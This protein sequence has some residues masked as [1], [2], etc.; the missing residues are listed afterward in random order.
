M[1]M[2]THWKRASALL[3]ATLLSAAPL[4]AEVE[5]EFR[6]R[7]KERL[8]QLLPSVDRIDIATS[9]V[10]GIYEVIVNG[11]VL[12][13]SE[14]ARH[15]FAGNL[16]DMEEGRNLTESAE[17]RARAAAIDAVGEENMI[18]FGADEERHV[19]TVFTD[20]ECP[21]CQKLHKAMDEYNERGITIRYL[22]FPRQGRGSSGWDKMVS[23][24]CADDPRVA[25]DRSKT[26]GESVGEQCEDHPV[27]E[28]YELAGSM[29]V[30]GTPSIITSEG[31]ILPGF[32]PP[33]KLREEL[34][35]GR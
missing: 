23:I 18:T 24:W 25:M 27:E 28:H 14:D 31:A 35:N 16:L 6:E 17:N 12:Y 11:R 15:V 3:L 30:R 32:V 33:E 13:V 26:G 4:S 19:V 2:Y 10:E 29:G 22:A 20:T 8:Q 5:P 21:Y 9:P 7:V 34:E 1:S